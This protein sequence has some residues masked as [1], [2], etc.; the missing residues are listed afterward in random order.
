MNRIYTFILNIIMLVL[1]AFMAINFFFYEF[2]D[3]SV[4]VV[5]VCVL[6]NIFLISFNFFKRNRKNYLSKQGD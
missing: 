5:G 2:P 1:T 3:W 4:R 6:I